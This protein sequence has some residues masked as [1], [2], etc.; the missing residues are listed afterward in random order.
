[1]EPVVPEIVVVEEQ[2]DIDVG[3]VMRGS[4]DF[5]PLL[6]VADFGNP[7]MMGSVWVKDFVG[8]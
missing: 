3:E 6:K 5:G 2:L 1:M 7:N 4:K 8:H